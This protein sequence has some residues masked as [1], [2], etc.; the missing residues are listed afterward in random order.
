MHETL[1]EKIVVG[2]IIRS[3]FSTI[4]GTCTR[5]QNC[6]LIMKAGEEAAIYFTMKMRLAEG[7][8]SL[9][10]AVAIAHSDTDVE[11]L[12]RREDDMIFT[13]IN[14]N[15]MEGIVDLEAKI[16]VEKSH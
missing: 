11:V 12:D 10:P 13:V 1:D 5:W 2:C 8:Y 6:D 4:Y 14:N 7:F 16:E 9:S 3:R 15:L